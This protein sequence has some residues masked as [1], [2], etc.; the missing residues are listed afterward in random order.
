MKYDAWLGPNS[1]VTK[2]QFIALRHGLWEP[3]G[4][5][6]STVKEIMLLILRSLSNQDVCV[7][8]VRITVN[9]KQLMYC[10]VYTKSFLPCG[11]PK[12]FMDYRAILVTFIFN[13]IL[14][15]FSNVLCITSNTNLKGLT[16]LQLRK[17][18]LSTDVSLSQVPR[19]F[20]VSVLLSN[21]I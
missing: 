17:G 21:W 3:A 2:M 19:V 15:N 8:Q 11:L 5:E 12:Q 13:L 4:G 6:Q 9:V 20:R 10:S 1:L 7:C 18:K 16:E 14:T